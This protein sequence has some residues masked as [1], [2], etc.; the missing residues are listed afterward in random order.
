MA[1]V[2]QEYI[3]VVIRLQ[4]LCGWLKVF[5]Y[6]CDIDDV[7]IRSCTMN[8]KVSEEGDGRDDDG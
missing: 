8:R 1:V 7:A 3:I 5:F 6:F 4:T 2:K